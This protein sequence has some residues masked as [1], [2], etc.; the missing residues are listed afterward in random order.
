MIDFD[1][2]G[3]YPSEIK[4]WVLSNVEYFKSIIPEGNYTEGWQVAHILEDKRLEDS[5]FVSDFLHNNC[6][7]EFCVWHATRI[8]NEEQFWNNGIVAMSKDIAQSEERI[9]RLFRS[10]GLNEDEI[11]PILKKIEYYWK[12]D[13]DSRL[14]TV[15]FFFAKDHIKDPRLN[16]FAINLGGE[17]VCW[18]LDRIDDKLY[19]MEPFKRLWI[20][21]K[22]SIIKFRCKL[23]DMDRRTQEHI[24]AELVRYY[25]ITELFKLPYAIECTGCRIG[26]VEAEDILVIDEIEDYIEMQEQFEEFKGFYDE[27]KTV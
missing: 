18:G 14:G 17:I 22:P 11:E 12:R 10:I 5:K 3:T 6:N 26:S 21:G 23:K 15:H 9:R 4:S 24:G 20:W 25:V 16:R 1:N 2:S 19:R 27:L 7:T 8:E 13:K